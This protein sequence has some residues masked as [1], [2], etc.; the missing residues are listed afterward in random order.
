MG[1]DGLNKRDVILGSPRGT[2]WHGEDRDYDDVH[3]SR[4]GV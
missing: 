1:V 2:E 4:T 3:F